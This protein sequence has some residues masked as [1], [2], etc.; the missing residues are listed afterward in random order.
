MKDDAKDE[1]RRRKR[2]GRR[3]SNVGMFMQRGM[4]RRKFIIVHLR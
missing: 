1:K 2:R 4:L 3:R